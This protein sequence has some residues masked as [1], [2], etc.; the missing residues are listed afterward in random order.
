MKNGIPNGY[1]TITMSDGG[2]YVGNLVDGKRAG[3]GT[4]T[5]ANGARYSGH[6]R[7]DKRY[8]RGILYDP[9]GNIIYNGEWKDDSPLPKGEK[10]H[11]NKSDYFYDDDPTG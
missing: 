10:L 4:Y 5:W 3:D 11:E 6:W 7:D 1:G 9:K 2:K 8:A